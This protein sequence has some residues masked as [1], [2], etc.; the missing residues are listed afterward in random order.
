MLSGQALASIHVGEV[1]DVKGLKQHL[2]QVYG[3]PPRFRQRVFFNGESLKDAVR[4]DSPMNL[5]LVLLTFTDVSARQVDDLGTAARQGSVSKVGSFETMCITQ[6]TRG[7]R[8]PYMCILHTIYGSKSLST[9]V[10]LFIDLSVYLCACLSA[11]CLS[12]YLITYLPTYPCIY[13][14]VDLPIYPSIYRGQA[15]SG[16]RPH[17]ESEFLK[18]EAA[19]L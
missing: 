9:S 16:K 14:P 15:P 6:T 18:P 13:L 7:M 8:L 5:D 17:A 1:S 2:T 12:I 10:Y 3:L 19:L 4:L 11:V